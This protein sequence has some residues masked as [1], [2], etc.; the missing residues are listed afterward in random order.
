MDDIWVTVL[1]DGHFEYSSQ[2]KTELTKGNVTM[3]IYF[4]SK[5]WAHLLMLAKYIRL[6]SFFFDY[7]WTFRLDC[8]GER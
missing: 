8:R 6:M 2:T 7:E 3:L 5:Q 1:L 4:L